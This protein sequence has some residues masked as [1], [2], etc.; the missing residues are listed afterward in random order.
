MNPIDTP[1][2]I[3]LASICML[4]IL[5]QNE[6]FVWTHLIL[7]VAK[8]IPAIA[9]DTIKKKIFGQ[10]FFCGRYNGLLL[11]GSTP[12]H[13]CTFVSGRDLTERGT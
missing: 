6:K 8:L 4:H 13:R 10:S 9:I 1:W 5:R 3:F 2:I 11:S 7:L 12:G